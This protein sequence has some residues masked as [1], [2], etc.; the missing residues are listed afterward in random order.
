MFP[1]LSSLSPWWWKQQGPLKRWYTPTR[2]HGA[3]T[4]K[5]AIFTLS[6][7]LPLS[8][9]PDLTPLQNNCHQYSPLEKSVEIQCWLRI[10]W[11][12][13]RLQSLFSAYLVEREAAD[14]RDQGAAG[15]KWSLNV[16]STGSTN[17]TWLLPYVLLL[18]RW[19]IMLNVVDCLLG[20]TENNH[21]HLW[22][23]SPQPRLELDTSRMRTDVGP[24]VFN[25]TI[26]TARLCTVGLNERWLCITR[27]KGLG[28][29]R[30]WPVLSVYYFVT[31]INCLRKRLKTSWYPI[32]W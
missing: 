9:R 24:R 19:W 16:K 3:T 27:W 6:P 17:G 1:E 10:I 32:S 26:S 2:L 25:D 22:V 18:A 8:E 4:Q 29:K 14:L 7:V 12:R 20:G 21:V 11:R 28:R 5:T 23:A 13:C 30:S 31:G 15:Q